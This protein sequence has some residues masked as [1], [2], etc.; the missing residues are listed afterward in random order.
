MG[1]ATTGLIVMAAGEEESANDLQTK[2][3][4]TVHA[5]SGLLILTQE[6]ARHAEPR[7]AEQWYLRHGAVMNTLA[8]VDSQQSQAAP[9]TELRSSTASLP[10]FFAQLQ[11][12]GQLED[13]FALRRKEVLLDQFLTN[14]QGMSDHAA[15]WYSQAAEA[16]QAAERRFRLLSLCMPAVSLL[17]V[18]ALAVFVARRVLKP[19]SALERAT[20]AVAAGNLSVRLEPAASDE[21][22]AL[23]TRFNE[24][25]TALE[26]SSERVRKSERQLR[27]V[28]DNLP[29]LI[30]YFDADQR[31]Q[32]ANAHHRQ[33]FRTDP[34]ALIGCRIS[35]CLTASDYEQL[36]G[37][38]E[39]VL[40][41]ERR[42]SELDQFGPD[43]DRHKTADLVPDMDTNGNVH[44]FYA[45]IADVTE[46]RRSEIALEK[47]ER[48]LRLVADN[49]P[50]LIAYVDDQERFAFANAHYKVLM[51]LDPSKIVGR[52]VK[53]II[54]PE[55]YLP[56]EARLRAARSGKRQRY[57][58]STS[59]LGKTT[60]LIAEYIPDFGQ[61]GQV[62]GTFTMAFDIT[63]QKQIEWSLQQSELRLRAITNNIPAAV[64]HFDAG[65]RC[66]FANSAAMRF[67]G[68]AKG[69][70]ARH[71]LDMALSGVQSRQTL[72]ESVQK[73][74]VVQFEG[75]AVRKERDIYY[76]T[77]LIPARGV[78]QS[79]QGVYLMSFDM[80]AARLA[81]I[82]AS[83][84]E[85]RLAKI[86]DNLPV[87]ISYLDSDL[88][89]QFANATYKVW[90][91]LDP[92]TLLGH[93]SRDVFGVELYETRRPF[94]ERAL[95]GELVHFEDEATV[96][97]VHRICSVSYIPDVDDH[98][99][100]HGLYSLTTDITELKTVERQLQSLARIDTLTGLPN[101]LQFNERLAA[102]LLRAERTGDAISLM[103][104]DVDRFKVINDTY[105]HS[106]G[107]AVLKEF[108]KR[109]LASVRTTDTVARLGGDEFVIILEHLGSKGEPET[110]AR[111][112]VH[113]MRQPLRIDMAS[114]EVTTSIGVA[115]YLPGREHI[116]SEQLLAKADDA[117]YRAKSAGRNTYFMSL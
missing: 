109:L 74:E 77:H 78:D 93:F 64:S 75:H 97:G 45:L 59:L 19:L 11:E 57:E 43:R 26:M 51:G 5:V 50:I 56:V 110:I 63:E 100:V 28:T 48:L 111:K 101:R 96:H 21:L 85:Q 104:L 76:Q 4:A 73:G 10:P 46:R 37:D 14:A 103:F 33:V 94:L 68:I 32:F 89:L 39:R 106:S 38:V 47:S 114:I 15:Q 35:E 113:G 65:G 7:A 108:A 116:D 17:L 18:G 24:M 91:G 82:A 34:E 20:Q 86:T 61:D 22:G 115:Y 62:R 9:L 27:A 36:R 1:L 92:R 2:A 58:R 29:V 117:L 102:A 12:I 25:T 69:E 44:G 79:V 41:G 53:E 49:L 16:R 3:Q 55:D 98:G 90:L 84:S 80:T 70:E 107:D 52:P 72:I 13:S 40:D 99:R 67:H 54:E 87:L 60:H 71:S 105:G 95:R 112:I 42:H 31:F 6:Y 66:L 8:S 23:S 83:R 81:E 88:R 30:A